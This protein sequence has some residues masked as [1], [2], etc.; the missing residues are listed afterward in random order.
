[1][2]TTMC[3]IVS[4]KG[5]GQLKHGSSSE[6]PND[7]SLDKMVNGASNEGTEFLKVKLIVRCVMWKP[8]SQL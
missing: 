5:S 1:M 7:G 4:L 3:S 8:G 6:Y 2:T